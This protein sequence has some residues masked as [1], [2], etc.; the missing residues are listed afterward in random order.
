MRLISFEQ[1]RNA[2]TT[3]RFFGYT[4]LSQIGAEQEILRR[5]SR[6]RFTCGAG[7]HL[8]LR[9]A[10]AKRRAESAY[11][12][13]SLPQPTTEIQ[14]AWLLQALAIS[15][16]MRLSLLS[17][18]P[19]FVTIEEAVVLTNARQFGPVERILSRDG[20]RQFRI[21]EEILSCQVLVSSYG[22]GIEMPFGGVKSSGHGHVEGLEALH[23]FATLKTVAV[24]HG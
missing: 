2:S 22:C 8:S 5:A 11:R 10:N 12:S 4:L 19:W 20:T 24:K 3:S 21:A 1:R 6:Q 7:S 17:V 14:N 16:L 23:G 9:Y 13:P 18:Y 15:A